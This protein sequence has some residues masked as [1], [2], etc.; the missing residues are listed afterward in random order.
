MAAIFRSTAT[1]MP[2]SLPISFVRQLTVPR[3][4]RI[5]NMT[6]MNQNQQQERQGDYTEG[7]NP[8]IKQCPKQET[9]IYLS[10]YIRNPALFPDSRSK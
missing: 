4:R 8:L 1:L 3:S 2:V 10:I 5:K 9:D 7:T 6:I